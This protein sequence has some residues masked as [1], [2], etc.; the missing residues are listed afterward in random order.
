MDRAN[1]FREA[2]AELN[3]HREKK[4]WRYPAALRRLAVVYCREHRRV[5]RPW[6]EITEELGVSAV[7]LGRW[8]SS[9]EPEVVSSPSPVFHPVEVVEADVKAVPAVLRVV[10]PGGLQIEG[11]DFA[12]VLE[13]ARSWR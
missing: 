10:T 2:A 7:T 13:L 12:Q 3:R 6:S 1:R 11:L 4:G 8:L 9:V 5:G